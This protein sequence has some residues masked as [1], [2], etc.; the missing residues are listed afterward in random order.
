M[1]VQIQSERSAAAAQTA[2]Q[3]APGPGSGWAEGCCRSGEAHLF[4][5]LFCW[6]SPPRG[7]H[8]CSSAPWIFSILCSWALSPVVTWWLRST[9]V[10][11]I[12]NRRGCAVARGVR[13]PHSVPYRCC[14]ECNP[15]VPLDLQPSH[16]LCSGEA[17]S[18][19]CMAEH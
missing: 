16:G 15:V 2:P 17:R 5:H 9:S 6:V 19:F 10:S 1:K 3:P 8:T 7:V 12:C 4:P 13:G 18:C 14:S 11:L